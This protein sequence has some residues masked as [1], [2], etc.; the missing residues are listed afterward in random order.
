MSEERRRRER[1]VLIGVP[2]QFLAQAPDVNIQRAG[3]DFGAVSPYLQEQGI[4][5]DNLAGVPHQQ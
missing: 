4:A 5:R 1:D 3:A 2:T